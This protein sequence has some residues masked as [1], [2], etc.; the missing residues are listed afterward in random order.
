M[1]KTNFSIQGFDFL[2][3]LTIA[4]PTSHCDAFPTLSVSLAVTC[5]LIQFGALFTYLLGCPAH[6]TFSSFQF[7]CAQPFFCMFPPQR[8]S[9]RPLSPFSTP[10]PALPGPHPPKMDTTQDMHLSLK[11][12]SGPV[13]MCQTGWPRTCLFQF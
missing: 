5:L 13:E 6:G 12:V 9:S 3:E 7:T 1:C 11:V 4:S 10:S 8:R 2:A